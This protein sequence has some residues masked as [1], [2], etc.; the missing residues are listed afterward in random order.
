MSG[1]LRIPSVEVRCSLLPE[2]GVMPFLVLGGRRPEPEWLARAAAMGEHRI[3]AVDAG[4]GACIAAGA[5]PEEIVGDMDSVSP[6]D[7]QR[8]LEL[9]AAETLY[10]RDKDLTDLQLALKRLEPG[11]L[12]VTGCFGGRLDHLLSVVDSVSAS[13][14]LPACMADH[15]EGAFIIRACGEPVE[16]ELRF[17]RDMKAVSLL[18]MSERC[19]GVSISGVRWALEGATLERRSQWAISNEPRGD[20]VRASLTDGTLAICWCSEEEPLR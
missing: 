4:I 18:S 13:P 3:I 1:A 10:D 5:A 20:T 16:A 15:R 17:E 6:E 8:A 19:D 9:G 7:R 11:P 2:R 14:M 12:I